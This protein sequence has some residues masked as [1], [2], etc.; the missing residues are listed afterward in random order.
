M[1]RFQVFSFWLISIGISPDWLMLHT[2]TPG[3]TAN[4]LSAIANQKYH[5]QNFKVSSHFLCVWGPVR[6][7][8]LSSLYSPK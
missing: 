2:H 4:L 5:S 3:R 8:F 7:S 1:S 6:T